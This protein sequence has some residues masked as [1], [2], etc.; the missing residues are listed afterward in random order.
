MEKL[1]Y[2]TKEIIATL[3]GAVL[4][5]LFQWLEIYLIKA[6]IMPE[7]IYSWVQFRV[8]VVAVVAIFFGPVSGMLCGL[9]GDLLVNA[10]FDPFI[11]YPEVLS[12]GLYGLFMGIYYGKI[13]FDRRHFTPADFVD[14]NAIQILCALFCAMF[15]VPLTAFF[16]DE[17]S[18]YDTI[19]V[20]ARTV[21]GNSILTG[22]VCP[23]IMGATVAIE[24][25]KRKKETV[26]REF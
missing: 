1:R 21:V 12:L 7:E 16:I 14:F 9:G 8:V 11:S 3:L 15:F 24:G 10:V 13:H 4:F 20:S 22:I 19:S 5:M 6:G 23:V 25:R 18:I 2:G 17:N 26:I